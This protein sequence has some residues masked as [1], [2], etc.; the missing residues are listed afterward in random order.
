MSTRKTNLYEWMG[1]GSLN[2]TLTIGSGKQKGVVF[3]KGSEKPK[4]NARYVTDD[5][6]VQAALEHCYLFTSGRIKRL[7]SVT[8]V[9]QEVSGSKETLGTQDTVTKK[10]N[11]AS[12]KSYQDAA[13]KLVEKY[14]IA[15]ELLTTPE[16][17]MSEAEKVGA[18]FPNLVIDPL[19]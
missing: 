15:Q 13:A 17:I 14:G 12:V 9:D 19:S 10:Q 3:P 5:P 16:D 18:L 7:S 2:L 11:Y 6:E 8:S 1:V 4:L